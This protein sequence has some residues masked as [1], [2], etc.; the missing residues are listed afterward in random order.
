MASL[1]PSSLR[2]HN[3]VASLSQAIEKP[4]TKSKTKQNSKTLMKAECLKLAVRTN[5]T[6]M[7]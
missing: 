4:I 6:V 5:R 2:E 7:S 3:F 1:P